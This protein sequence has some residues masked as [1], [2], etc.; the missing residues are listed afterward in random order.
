MQGR[1]EAA[2]SIVIQH[3]FSH[4]GGGGGGGGHRGFGPNP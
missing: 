1:Q 2:F 4:Y 3:P